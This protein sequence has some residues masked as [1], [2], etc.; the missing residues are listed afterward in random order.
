MQCAALDDAARGVRAPGATL[1]LFAAAATLGTIVGLP[2]F[3]FSNLVVLGVGDLILVTA[4][5]E[6]FRPMAAS[7][8]I[9]AIPGS[10][11]V[12]VGTLIASLPVAPSLAAG[13]FLRR[14]CPT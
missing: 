1:V 6:N 3:P 14:S 4:L 8:P 10:F 2:L 5:A 9:A 13:A 7:W 11:A 12:V